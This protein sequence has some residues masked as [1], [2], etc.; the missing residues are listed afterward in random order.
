MAAYFD[1]NAV[2]SLLFLVRGSVLF[3]IFVR[4]WCV[5]GLSEEWI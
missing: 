1:D 3:L 2:V 5:V 4:G